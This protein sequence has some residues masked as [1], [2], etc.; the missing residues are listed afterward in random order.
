MARAGPMLATRGR[1]RTR[2]RRRGTECGRCYSWCLAME[3]T[4]GGRRSD[5]VKGR[6]GRRSPYASHIEGI[7][8]LGEIGSGGG[9]GRP[10]KHWHGQ[11]PPC[12]SASN[13]RRSSAFVNV[14]DLRRS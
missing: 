9:A 4:R 10:V 3:A 13:S 7:E 2:Q 14:P 8:H 1:A 6:R 11:R 12:A 5:G